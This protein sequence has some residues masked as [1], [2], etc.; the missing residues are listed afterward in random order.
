MLY[1][2]PISFKIFIRVLARKKQKV[3]LINFMDNLLFNYN[4][5]KNY[6]YLLGHNLSKVSNISVFNN[7]K[8]SIKIKVN[9]IKCFKRLNT[10]F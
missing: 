6:L 9:L 8:A 10:F 3:L 2:R 7:N 1:K 4:Y 5:K